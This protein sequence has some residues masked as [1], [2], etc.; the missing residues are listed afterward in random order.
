MFGIGGTELVV[1][2]IVLLIAVGP[3]RL[4]GLLKAVVRAYREFRR[5]TREL[6]ASTGIDDIL[7][8]ED[9]KDLRKP[10]YVPPAKTKA[11]PA[12]KPSVQKRAI[13]YADRVREV[14]PEGIDLAVLREDARRREAEK[15][16]S[17]A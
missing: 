10:L 8:D 6:R 7:Q 11:I 15:A 16:A 2:A 3:T 4:P 17:E 13:R 12:K 14:P 9:L 5:A 1:I